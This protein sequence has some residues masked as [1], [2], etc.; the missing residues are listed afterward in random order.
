MARMSYGRAMDRLAEREPEADAVLFD[1][2]SDSD[3]DSDGDGG[4]GQAGAARLSRGELARRSNRLA[5]AY[6][7]LGV[8]RGDLVTLALPNGLEFFEA[9]LAVWKLGAT[10]NPI[11]ARLP[12]VERRAIVDTADPALLVGA[13]PGDY[14]ARPTLP[15]GFE[16]DP[17][18]DDSPLPA[19]VPTHARAMT[20]G[21]STGR[22]KVII[23][24]T[25]GECDPEVPEN[26]MTAGG[27]TLVPGPLYH[28]G[29]FI[30]AWQQLC[31]GGRV[32]LMSRFDALR[33]LELIERERVDWVLFVPTM[34][35]RIWRL[36]EAERSR[37]DL[38]SLATVM[39]SGAPSPAWLKRAWI[40][41]LGPERIW[42]AYGGSERI[43][44]TMISGA[45]WLGH[46]GSVGR[47]TA[48][49]R[50]RILDDEGRD[51]PPREIGLVYM[52]PPGGQGST[53]RYLGAE[54]D[55]TD[56][57]WETLGDMGYVDEEGYLYLVDRKTDMIVTGGANV[58]PA[59]VEAAIDDHPAV[60]S[61]AVIGLPDEDLG[62]RVHAIVDAPD[63]PDGD[64]LRRHLAER[65][66]GYKIPRSF[67]FVDEPLRDDAGKVRRSAL[68]EQR[69]TNAA[70]A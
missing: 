3:S 20:S 33:A 32:V 66:V 12:E 38:G 22:P 40:G 13:E 19:P 7:A 11:S 25:P 61:S 44:G 8:G 14:G 55:A 26:R 2:D 69:I 24:A 35:Q 28:A 68:R 47:P 36:P 43:G 60:R 50:I 48:N 37:F 49:R 1:S 64:A 6:A 21:G 67:E 9:C 58:Y 62:Q 29:P 31:C 39:S 30:T 53:Y 57:G 10:P 18:V 4:D 41:W 27:T 51:L 52:M 54:A 46:P 56:E 15:R 16:P 23:D 65:L 34:M 59:E 45:E 17:A 70:P 5:R 63:R 42:E